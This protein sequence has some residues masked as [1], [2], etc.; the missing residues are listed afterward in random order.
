MGTWPPTS[1]TIRALKNAFGKALLSADAKLRASL[2]TEDGS[3]VPPQGG[4]FR[5]RAEMAKHF[6]T[7]GPPAIPG[8]RSPTIGRRYHVHENGCIVST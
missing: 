6:E 5:G 1:G 7:E 8:S 2:W 3:V 4:Y